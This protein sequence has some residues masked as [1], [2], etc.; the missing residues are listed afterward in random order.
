M[1]TFIYTCLTCDKET[2]V[3]RNNPEEVR[4]LE[5]PCSYC[6]ESAILSEIIE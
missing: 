4:L 2:L 3:I 6:F 5:N 1:E